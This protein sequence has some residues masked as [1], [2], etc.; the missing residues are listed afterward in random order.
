[1]AFTAP[2]RTKLAVHQGG[3]GGQ[4]SGKYE[5]TEPRGSNAQIF[6]RGPR[7]LGIQT[8]SKKSKAESFQRAATAACVRKSDL[9]S[10]P[11]RGAVKSLEAIDPGPAAPRHTQ[12]R[13]FG[14][15]F[16]LRSGVRCV[17]RDWSREA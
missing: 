16:F 8:K 13:G 14:E 1:M 2:K 4:I 10:R 5:A 11:L 3:P 6:F 12:F 15:T 9:F 17:R 7:I